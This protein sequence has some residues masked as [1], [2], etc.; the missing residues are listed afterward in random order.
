VNL[1]QLTPDKM[2]QRPGHNMKANLQ[3]LFSWSTK[4]LPLFKKYPA[5]WSQ[6]AY[7]DCLLL[8]RNCCFLRAYRNFFPYSLNNAWYFGAGL[9]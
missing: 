3:T 5:P 1:I 9:Y 6:V 7:D 8:C 4:Y 2:Q